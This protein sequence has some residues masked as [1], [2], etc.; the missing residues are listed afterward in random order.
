MGL[1]STSSLLLSNIQRNGGYMYCTVYSFFLHQRGYHSRG[2]E[3]QHLS[4]EAGHA[5][6]RTCQRGVGVLYSHL[7]SPL[8]HYSFTLCFLLPSAM[9]PVGPDTGRYIHTQV[10]H[11]HLWLQECLLECDTFSIGHGPLCNFVLFFCGWRRGTGRETD[12]MNLV[13]SLSGWH[14]TPQ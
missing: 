1:P 3:W 4:V 9:A 5:A 2:C 13:K 10:N 7:P 12:S 8:L 6:C 14:P 11:H